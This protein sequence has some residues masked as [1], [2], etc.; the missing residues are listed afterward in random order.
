MQERLFN[1]VG[2]H[3]EI[4]HGVVYLGGGAVPTPRSYVDDYVHCENNTSAHHAVLVTGFL[5]LVVFIHETSLS[6][7][8]S[9]FACQKDALV[10]VLVGHFRF[11]CSFD[12]SY[13]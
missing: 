6:F 5:V 13:L 8:C 9:Y 1:W 12:Y 2:A 7:S 10:L 11:S 4:T 3:F